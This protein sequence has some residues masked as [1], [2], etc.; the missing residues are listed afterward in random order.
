MYQLIYYF[1]LI[2]IALDFVFFYKKK[3]ITLNLVEL[4]QMRFKCDQIDRV[5]NW[6]EIN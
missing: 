6:I 3:T 4:E 2:S 5:E 1:N